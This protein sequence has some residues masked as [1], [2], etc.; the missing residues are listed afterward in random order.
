MPMLVEAHALR[1]LAF[2][3]QARS[4]EACDEFL[5]Y[6]GERDCYTCN[7][8]DEAHVWKKAAAELF[9]LA[10]EKAVHST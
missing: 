10:A 8:P 1:A 4:G 2:R 3:W 6:K 7:C 5:E 9:A